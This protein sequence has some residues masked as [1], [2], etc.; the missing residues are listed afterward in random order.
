M[1]ALD[2]LVATATD[3]KKYAVCIECKD[4]MTSV[5]EHGSEGWICDP[6]EAEVRGIDITELQSQAKSSRAKARVLFCLEC[7][8]EI[9]YVWRHAEKIIC[10]CQGDV[11]LFL[12][13]EIPQRKGTK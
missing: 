11:V 3:G 7:I 10:K 13:V 4:T 1:N 2:S 12:L 5:D 6:C 8:T 9:F